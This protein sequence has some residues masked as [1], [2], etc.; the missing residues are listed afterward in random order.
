MAKSLFINSKDVKTFTSINGNLDPDRYLNAVYLAQI[1]HIQTLLG[2]DLYNRLA[3][4][5]ENDSLNSDYRLLLDDYVKPILIHYTLVEMLP[6]IHYQISN[7]GIFKHRSENA[8][9]ASAEEVDELIEKER[10]A[11]QFYADRF[12][13]FIKNNTTTYPEY[14]TNSG[15]D[16]YPDQTAHYTG[17]VLD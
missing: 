15:A 14:Y 9:T 1:T 11:A 13:D 6:R 12:L 3:T 4:D 7:K 2:T 16:L 17:M 10:S 8:E 5:I